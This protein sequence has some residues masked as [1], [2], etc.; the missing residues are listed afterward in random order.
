MSEPFFP[1]ARRLSAGHELTESHHLLWRMLALIPA[2]A[3]LAWPRSDA[4][5]T[6]HRCHGHKG[7]CPAAADP[8]GR[9]C[10][11]AVARSVC[12]HMRCHLEAHG[13]PGAVPATRQP[14]SHLIL[15]INRV[16]PCGPTSIG[17]EAPRD[18]S[19]AG[20][21]QHVHKAEPCFRQRMSGFSSPCSANLPSSSAA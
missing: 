1:E 20:V 7:T 10:P 8:G 17:E 6:P 5:D 3:R 14:Q 12:W 19:L 4:V 15:T 2:P 9:W 16:R 13:A 11:P 21:P 18:W